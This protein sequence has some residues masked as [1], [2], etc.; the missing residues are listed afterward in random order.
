MLFVSLWW[1]ALGDMPDVKFSLPRATIVWINSISNSWFEIAL[2]LAFSYFSGNSLVWISRKHGRYTDNTILR[3]LKCLVFRIPKPFRTFDEPLQPIMKACAEQLGIPDDKDTWRR[4]YPVSKIILAENLTRSLV[5]TY[6]NK[7]TLHRSIT[8]ASV[9]LF[10]LSLLSLLSSLFFY[11]FFHP[12]IFSI[13]K[14]GVLDLV[15][16]FLIWGFSASFSYYYLMFGNVIVTETF[17][18]LSNMT[19]KRRP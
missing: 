9:V 3:V 15:S 2:L 11:N 1:F 13:I 5:S 16:L 18:V 10:W 17:S 19:G 6:Q 7:Y 14:L 4:L 8:G 12:S